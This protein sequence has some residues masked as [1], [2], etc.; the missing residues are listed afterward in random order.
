MKCWTVLLFCGTIACGSHQ[1]EAQAPAKLSFLSEPHDLSVEMT[2][3]AHISNQEITY[4]GWSEK[5]TRTMVNGHMLECRLE[6]AQPHYE[7]YVLTGEKLQR[8][9]SLNGNERNYTARK[10]A[11]TTGEKPLSGVFEQ[12]PFIFCLD[13]VMLTIRVRETFSH[14]KLTTKI[15][16]H[17]EPITAD[18]SE[19]A[20]S[21]ISR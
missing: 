10:I 9:I 6:A 17:Y 1:E 8:Q 15:K 7:S 12:E 5:V 18:C 16:C 14:D 19:R 2:V 20:S 11:E 13:D 3:A 4:D 21:S